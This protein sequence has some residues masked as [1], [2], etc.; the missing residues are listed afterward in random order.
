MNRA[1]LT[2]Y[3][4]GQGAQGRLDLGDGACILGDEVFITL[5]RGK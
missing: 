1:A 4:I 5:E 2:R 3:D